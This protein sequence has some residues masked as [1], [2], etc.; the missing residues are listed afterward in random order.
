MAELEEAFSLDKVS[1]SGGVFDV[2][3]LNWM[4]NQY[5]KACDLD[6]LTEL[7]IPYVI[8]AGQTSAEEAAKKF[9]W[10]KLAVQT[11]R[12][13]MDYL[14][15]FPDRIAMFLEK[16]PAELDEDALAFMKNEHMK[17]LAKY[18]ETEIQKLPEAFT[19]QD[20]QDMLKKI[21]QESGIKGKNLFMGSR[22]LL[23]GQMHG[24]D[25][26]NSLALI[27]K[28]ALLERL[29]AAKRYLD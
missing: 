4:N 26:N 11:V 28:E 2:Q 20:A 14:S 10:F 13:S 17:E 16:Y 15:I 25:I 6:K 8:E 7:C 27:G 12:E 5:I 1:K 9:D 18:L 22:V 23:T 21:Q 24:S 19:P 3:K 29:E